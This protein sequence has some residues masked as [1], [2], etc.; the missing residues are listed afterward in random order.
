MLNARLHGGFGSVGARHVLG[1]VALEHVA[2]LSAHR[3][4]APTCERSI[5]A[6]K[7]LVDRPG[8]HKP[9]AEQPYCG[10]IGHLTIEPQS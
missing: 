1:H 5:E 8:L 2:D 7:K 10:G 6:R 4:V 3:E 9:L